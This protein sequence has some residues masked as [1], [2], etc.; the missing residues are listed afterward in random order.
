MRGEGNVADGL[1]KNVDKQMMEQYLKACGFVKRSGRLESSMRGEC[2][3]VL[4]SVFRF[5]A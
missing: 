2:V 1:T 4:S 5:T 3:S